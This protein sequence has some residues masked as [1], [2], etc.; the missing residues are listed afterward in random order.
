MILG[1]LVSAFLSRNS[2]K[3]SRRG[4]F[5][6]IKIVYGVGQSKSKCE[7]RR[8]TS[9]AQGRVSRGGGGST[10]RTEKGYVEE[11]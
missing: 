1:L 7:R 5:H 4:G 3:S 2:A 9:E 8:K 11:V 10:R 6:Q